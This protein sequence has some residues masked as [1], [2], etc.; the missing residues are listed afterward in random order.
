[1]QTVDKSVVDIAIISADIYCAD[2]MLKR[3]Q[4]FAISRRDLEL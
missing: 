2:C 3:A 1:M 4:V